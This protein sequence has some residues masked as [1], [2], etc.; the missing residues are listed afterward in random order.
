MRVELGGNLYQNGRPITSWVGA[1]GLMQVMPGTYDDLRGRYYDLGGDPFDPHDNIMAGAAYMREMY[2]VYGAPGFLALQCRPEAARCL[3]HNTRPLPDETRRNVA[4]IGPYIMDSHPANRSPAEDYAMNVLPVEIP[5]GLRYGRA[6]QDR[7]DDTPP[8]SRRSGGAQAGSRRSAPRSAAQIRLFPH[9][10]GREHARS[11]QPPGF[12]P[13]YA[14]GRR[15]DPHAAGRR[16]GRGLGGAGRRV[17]QP[18]SG[19]RRGRASQAARARTRRGAAE[20]CERAAGARR[21]V[22]RAPDRT[23]RDAA[24]DACKKLARSRTN[25]I[26]LSPDSQS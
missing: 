23:S 8:V 5:A 12:Q 17:R 2:D 6:T 13:D 22:A 14:R 10:R 16:Y 9:R 25:C 3:S 24:V 11:Q 15:A 4:M 19:E 1:M 18:K 26:V 20:S 7:S 21:S